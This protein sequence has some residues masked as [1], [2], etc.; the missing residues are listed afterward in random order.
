[1]KTKPSVTKYSEVL[2]EYIEPLLVEEETEETYLSKAR[3]GMIAWNY[4]VSL[5]NNLQG[6][7]EMSEIIRNGFVQYPESKVVLEFFIER[8]KMHCAQYDQFIF[9]VRVNTKPDGTKTLYVESVPAAIL[10]KA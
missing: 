6:T 3:A 7:S 5:E 1:M 2:S 4:C 9:D 8:K 10:D